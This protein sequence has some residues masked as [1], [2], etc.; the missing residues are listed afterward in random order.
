MS[1]R[2]RQPDALQPPERIQFMFNEIAP[3]YDLLNHLLS[4]GLDIRWRKRAIRL[5]GDKKG[6][7]ILDIAA[8]SGDCS[9]E[10][11]TLEPRLVIASDFAQNML[12]VFRQKLLGRHSPP[13]I[14]LAVC[15]ALHLPFRDGSFD[16][17]MV[18]FGIRNFADR[19][20]SMREMKRVLK[21]GGAALI[22]ELSEPK[23]I[24]TAAFYR[25][26]TRVLL[27]LLGKLISRNTSAYRYLPASI[28]GFPE[29]QEFRLLMLRA[30]FAT[31]ETHPLSFGVATIYIGRSTS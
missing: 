13:N 28:A 6:G 16:A 1:E 9:L 3:T 17:T 30:G 29:P 5:L 27:P 15:D 11:L 19:L 26:Y 14:Q 2:E 12:D 18:A 25:V 4:F 20:A 8:G 21:P 24:L 7:T 22:L 23:G 10:A 31:V